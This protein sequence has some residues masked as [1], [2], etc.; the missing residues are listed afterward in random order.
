MLW[1]GVKRG[2]VRGGKGRDRKWERMRKKKKRE[3]RRKREE[4]KGRVKKESG[5]N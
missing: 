4:T 1:R 2:T 3:E 5:E